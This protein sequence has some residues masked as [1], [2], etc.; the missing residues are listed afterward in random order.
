MVTH[1]GTP[2]ADPLRMYR[3][4][5]CRR[6]LAGGCRGIAREGRSTLRGLALTSQHSKRYVR[7][8]TPRASRSSSRSARQG[9]TERLQC[10]GT[11]GG[12]AH[13]I[14]VPRSP[15]AR[16]WHPLGCVSSLDTG[17]W[18]ATRAVPDRDR[19][20]PAPPSPGAERRARRRRCC[21]VEV[22]MPHALRGWSSAAGASA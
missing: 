6:V 1:A 5:A 4:D 9:G 17:H 13:A 2:F 19:P 21:F 16:S 22:Q 7:P 18:Q 10:A 12:A 3:L 14:S 20:E 8:H 11:W 15:R